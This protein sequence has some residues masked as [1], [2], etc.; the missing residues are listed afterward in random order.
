MYRYV[1][2]HPTY[3]ND[4]NGAAERVI[5]NGVPWSGSGQHVIPGAVARDRLSFLGTAQLE[6]LKVFRITPGGDGLH[7]N[8]A[9][10]KYGY[11]GAADSLV[12]EF[13]AVFRSKY[14]LNAGPIPSNLHDTFADDL[15]KAFNGQ[16][17]GT[18]ICDFNEAVRSKGT[19][20]QRE[21]REILKINRLPKWQLESRRGFVLLPL[22]DTPP[23]FP[24]ITAGAIG[25]V[26]AGLAEEAAAIY[27]IDDVLG[28]P[29]YFWSQSAYESS[30]WA[31]QDYYIGMYLNGTSNGLAPRIIEN[32][33]RAFIHSQME[34]ARMNG[35]LTPQQEIGYSQSSGIDDM[36]SLW[37]EIRCGR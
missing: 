3:A 1:G 10:G 29:T 35:T 9:H 16:P 17:Q 7:N 27:A 30:V 22:P 20:G 19:E 21:I 24:R 8:T 37:F 11:S 2:N 36:I 12:Q 6:R 23:R 33:G 25:A 31:R 5:V 14:S 26:G 4:P 18:I 28:T 15:M 32:R 13:E 34:R